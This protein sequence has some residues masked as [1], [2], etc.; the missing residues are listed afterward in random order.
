MLYSIRELQTSN[1]DAL[2]MQR[3]AA[4]TLF[5]LQKSFRQFI[6]ITSKLET[7]FPLRSGFESKIPTNLNP[8]DSNF[9]PVAIALPKWPAPMI[10]QSEHPYLKVWENTRGN[11]TNVLIFHEDEGYLVVLRKAKDYILPWTA[12]L[13]TYKSRKEKLLKE[14]EAYIKSK[15]R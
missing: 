8:L 9:I 14:Y 4:D 1:A 5:S 12:Y 6:G 11:K 10:N 13:V 15:E 3:T 2:G 7:Y